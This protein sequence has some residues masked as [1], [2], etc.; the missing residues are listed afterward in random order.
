MMLWHHYLILHTTQKVKFSIKDFFSKYDPI[1]SLLRIWSHL[2]K[3][4]LMENCIFLCSVFPSQLFLI[5]GAIFFLHKFLDRTI[6]IYVTHFNRPK[7]VLRSPD[8]TIK[9][10]GAEIFGCYWEDY[11]KVLYGNLPRVKACAIRKSVNNVAD[12]YL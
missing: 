4:S 11:I 1:R 9:T 8:F 6:S 12:L 3:K 7:K 10:L 2:L 5:N